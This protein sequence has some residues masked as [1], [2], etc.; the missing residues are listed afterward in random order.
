MT[1][2]AAEDEVAR[3]V[4]RARLAV[5]AGFFA[6]GLA[7]ALWA[8]HIPV[9]A[10]RLELSPAVLGLALLNVGLGG[11]I[12]QPI[13]G[14]FVA[15]T[16]SRPAA[17]VLLLVFVVAFIAPIVAWSTP[18]LFVGTFVFGAAAGACNVAINTQ[19]SEIERARGRPTMSW[20]HG[21]FSLGGLTGAF[22]GA[23]IMG[24]GWQGGG[25]AL[26]MAAV[27]VVIAAIASRQF[28]PT[29]PSSATA[30]A[31]R[32]MSFALPTGAILGLSLMTFFTNTVEGAVNDWSALYLVAVRG[33]T[34]ASAASGFAIFSLA[35]AVCRLA[36]GPVVQ[37]I[38]EKG[39]VLLGGVLIAAG[40]AAVVFSP[41]AFL[42][43]L[44]FGL[45]AIGA[46]NNIPVMMGA[47]SRAPGVAPSAGV[48]ATAT[49][50]LLGLLIGPPVSG[51]IAQATNLSIT[52]SLFCVVG[53][54]VAAGAALYRWPLAISDVKSVPAA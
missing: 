39:I 19:A 45:V 51:F 34:E 7:F 1:K 9:V 40:M 28:L 11:V 31:G 30:P 47:A 29:A 42:S 4:A 12:S 33:M 32:R 35:M 16:G 26:M 43:P 37:R 14:W 52:L 15:R 13:T 3:Q 36:G 46:A 27:L 5:S 44:G 22:V 24:A 41:W 48:A 25:G 10:K 38:G 54:V 50:A 20:F 18:I 2:A 53:I 23:G 49:G 8:V 17:T 6:F 21:F